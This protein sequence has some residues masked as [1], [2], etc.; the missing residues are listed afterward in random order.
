MKYEL[1]KVLPGYVEMRGRVNDSYTINTEEKSKYEQIT[2]RYFCVSEQEVD[3][4]H[5]SPFS[6]NSSENNKD[7]VSDFIFVYY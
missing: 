2:E 3:H 1:Q 7:F 6:K 5:F 4:L